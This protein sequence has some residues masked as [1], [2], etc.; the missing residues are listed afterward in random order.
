MCVYTY[1]YDTNVSNFPLLTP[2]F[3]TTL[4]ALCPTALCIPTMRLPL[5]LGRRRIVDVKRFYR[6]LPWKNHPRQRRKYLRTMAAAATRK[7]VRI[8]I[9]KVVVVVP[10]VMVM[11]MM[12]TIGL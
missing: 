1:L 12:T 10:P 8:R 11:I 9:V 2:R 5:P 6:S 4:R 7:L 3:V